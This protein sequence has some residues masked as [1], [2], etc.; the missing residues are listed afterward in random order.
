MRHQEEERSPTLS[1][2]RLE[3]T[4]VNLCIPRYHKYSQFIDQPIYFANECLYMSLLLA[5]CLALA[6]YYR[7]VCSYYGPQIWDHGRLL[8]WFKIVYLNYSNQSWFT[9][10]MLVVVGWLAVVKFFHFLLF[11]Y[12][13]ITGM[14]LDQVLSPHYHPYLYKLDKQSESKLSIRLR[15]KDNKGMAGNI[16]RFL[17]QARSSRQLN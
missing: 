2:R 9:I 10:F 11:S 5:E 15:N 4:K 1:L 13:T 14:T 6:W 8:V 12:C 17:R 7:G 16:I 3:V